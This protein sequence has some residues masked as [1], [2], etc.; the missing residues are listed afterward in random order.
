[1]AL[2]GLDHVDGDRQRTV[3]QRARRPPT[4]LTGVLHPAAKR[5]EGRLVEGR[6]RLLIGRDQRQLPAVLVAVV[7]RALTVDAELI[8]RQNPPVQG[9]RMQDAVRDTADPAVSLRESSFMSGT[10]LF[11]THADVECTGTSIDGYTH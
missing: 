6:C 11:I 1:M 8:S 4:L 5:V 7:G 9:S 10:L 3:P 2:S